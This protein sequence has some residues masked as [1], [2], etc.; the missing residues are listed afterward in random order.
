MSH[1]N[2][3][4]SEFEI[5]RLF[6]ASRPRLW[7][8]WADREQLAQ[9]FG[10]KGCTISAARHEFRPG[11]LFHYSMRLPDGQQMWGKFVY[12]EI[13]PQQRIVWVNSFS[14]ENGGITRHPLNASW[15]RE[16]FSTAEFLEQGEK[17]KLIIHWKPINPTEQERQTFESN[18]D[19]MIKGWTGT[20]DQLAAHLAKS[21]GTAA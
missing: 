1:P 20:F 4:K 19:S 13:V 15:P 16:M 7:Q 5:S 11:G 10:P 14:D 21:K 8:A 9:W 3:Q 2:Q 12:Q 6:D 17:T 18:H